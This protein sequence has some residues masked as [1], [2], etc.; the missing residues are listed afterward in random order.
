MLEAIELLRQLIAGILLCGISYILAEYLIWT[1]WMRG[2][3]FVA[4]SMSIALILYTMVRD[5]WPL[6]C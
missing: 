5:I 2:V 6:V 1:W 3:A 4:S